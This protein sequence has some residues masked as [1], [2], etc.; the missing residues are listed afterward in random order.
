MPLS[1]ELTRMAQNVGALNVDTNAIFEALRAKG[2]DVPPGT[3]LSDAAD[4]I[5]GILITEKIKDGI[6]QIARIGNLWFTIENLHEGFTG[7][8][9]QYDSSNAFRVQFNGESYYNYQSI[10]IIDDWLRQ[11]TQWR[12]ATADDFSHLMEFNP[13]DL[14]KNGA[15]SSSTTNK[16]LFSSIPTGYTNQSELRQYGEHAYF[17]AKSSDNDYV[18][19]NLSAINITHKYSSIENGMSIRLCKDASGYITIGGRQ[20]KTVTIGNQEWLAENLDYKF[21]VNGSQ[22]PIGVSGNPTTPAAWYYDNN[23]ATYGI[24]GTYKC[25]LLYNWYAAKYLDDNKSALLPSGWHVPSKSDWDTLATEIGGASTAGTKLKALD[26]SVISGF[27]SGW[28]GTDE[29][30][31]NAIPSGYEYN[32]T[33]YNF[34]VNINIQALTEV[35]SN[36][37]YYISIGRG[38]SD[39]YTNNG[40]K[41]YGLSIRLVRTLS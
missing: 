24:D 29:Y 1:T 36:N 33:S 25:G 10:S 40:T 28:N 17:Q 26:D 31:F 23:D 18:Q 11:N 22:I 21:Q 41:T 14:C 16:S 7:I 3:K 19:I 37:S 5:R 30:G 2:V 38:S 20:Y 12:V 34:G 8:S 39:I 4:L 13:N 35:D 9:D 32:G 15:W 27:P 6:Y